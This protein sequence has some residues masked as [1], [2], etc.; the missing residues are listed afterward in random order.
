MVTVSEVFDV[1]NAL[2]PVTR[3][4]DFDNVGILVGHPDYQ[5]TKVLVSL[6]ITD[7]VVEEAISKGVELIVSHHPLFFSINN[8]RSDDLIGKT[9]LTLVENKIAAICMHTNLDVSR[10]GV[11]DALAETL[12]LTNIQCL[13]VDGIDKD[14]LEYGLGR[15]GYT[16]KEYHFVEY[17]A[18]VNSRLKANG[19]RY[20]DAEK[21]VKK[22]AVCG[23]S[24]GSELK[25]AYDTGCDTYVTA[26]V[27][28]NVFLDAVNL[29]IN[30]ID[31][32]HFPTENVVV[33]PVKKLLSENFPDVEFFVSKFHVQ[34][35]HFYVE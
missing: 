8:I 1:L 13:T 22:V 11:N 30:L 7:E 2:A 23:G 35:E 6:D 10:G 28:Y 20:V 27:K 3:K 32:G 9:V 29:G 4:M 14:N 25:Y 15:Y 5:V 18:H 26:D 34:P 17:L 19:L 16:E 31:A 24:G 12:G 33:E 21:P